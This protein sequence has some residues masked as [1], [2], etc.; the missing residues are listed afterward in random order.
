VAEAFAT[1]PKRSIDFA[2]MEHT[3]CAFVLPV[4]CDRDDIGDWV[5]LERLLQRHGDGASTVAGGLVGLEAGGNIV[6]AEDESDVIVTVGVHDLVV[7]K[8]GNTVLL[9][10][11]DRVADIKRVLEE[12]ETLLR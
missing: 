8:H 9:M 12:Q 4:D 5:A 1:L 3:E 2:V 7:V 10:P 6:Y 11:K